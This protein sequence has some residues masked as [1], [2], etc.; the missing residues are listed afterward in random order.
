MTDR[1]GLQLLT[2]VALGYARALLWAV[3]GGWMLATLILLSRMYN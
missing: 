2:G 3:F 1:T